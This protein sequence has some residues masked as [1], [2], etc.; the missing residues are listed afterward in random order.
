MIGL[1]EEHHQTGYA[2][3]MREGIISEQQYI[4]ASS[5][6]RHACMAPVLNKLLTVQLVFSSRRR[7]QVS[8]MTTMYAKG[9]CNRI[10]SGIAMSALRCIG[11][12]KNFVNMM[13]LL[14][15]ELKHHVCTGYG[16]ACQRR[17]LCPL[18]TRSDME[19]D[20]VAA[21]LP[22]CGH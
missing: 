17:L 7:H 11:Y 22:S 1:C 5:D 14:W 16:M 6:M 18:T 20:K 3:L 8:C 19:S 21:H 15:A 9:C 4:W 13:G 12:S 2:R 10:V